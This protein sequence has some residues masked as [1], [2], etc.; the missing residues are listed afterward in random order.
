MLNDLPKTGESI[1]AIYRD[2]YDGEAVS[3]HHRTNGALVEDVYFS[4]FRARALRK[5]NRNFVPPRFGSEPSQLPEGPG[6]TGAAIDERVVLIT[7]Y[8][9]CGGEPSPEILFRYKSKLVTA[10]HDHEERDIHQALM[11]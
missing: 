6:K 8:G 4:R 1:P 7:E 3:L 10:E 5:N 11:V 2:R 9:A